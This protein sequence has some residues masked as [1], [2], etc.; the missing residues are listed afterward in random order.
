MNEQDKQYGVQGLE[1]V[2]AQPVEATPVQPVTT[3][4]EQAA[5]PDTADVQKVDETSQEV[6][7]PT[8]SGSD[9]DTAAGDAEPTDA[10]PTPSAPRQQSDTQPNL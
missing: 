10:D 4:P 7:Q 9:T 3:S 2:G 6:P 5:Q 8:D 1:S